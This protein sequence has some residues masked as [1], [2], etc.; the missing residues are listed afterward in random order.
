MDND[1][2]VL[3]DWPRLIFFGGASEGLVVLSPTD[4]SSLNPGITG[5]FIFDLVRAFAAIT[6]GKGGVGAVSLVIELTEGALALLRPRVCLARASRASSCGSTPHTHTRRVWRPLA[7][8]MAPRGRAPGIA[9]PNT[10]ML[11]SCG[12]LWGVAS[13][14]VHPIFSA[15]SSAG[16][17]K[18]S[19][20]PPPCSRWSPAAS[21]FPVMR[22]K[23]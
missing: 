16:L 4:P 9:Q 19:A 1:I 13:N 11:G 6:I 20:S 15:A 10:H 7:E 2:H 8:S 17:S 23:D 18:S 14:V 21:L 12:D 5:V 22:N 3:N